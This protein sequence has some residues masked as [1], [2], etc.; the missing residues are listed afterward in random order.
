MRHIYDVGHHL[1]NDQ[2]S[3]E[4][5]TH[6]YDHFTYDSK[7][8]WIVACASNE[9]QQ[10]MLFQGLSQ[11]PLSQLYK[12]TEELALQK[13]SNPVIPIIESIF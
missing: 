4:R 6:F 8:L 13:M 3:L 9:Q 2:V 11:R 7:G 1:K 10:S 12:H 5:G